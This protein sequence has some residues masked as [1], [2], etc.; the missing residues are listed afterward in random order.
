MM[1]PLITTPGHPKANS[2]IS[3]ESAND[4]MPLYDQKW[5]C[6]SDDEKVVLL[7]KS[8]MSLNA[9]PF[10]G[11]PMFRRQPLAFPR[12][13][14]ALVLSATS[15]GSVTHVTKTE[16]VPVK[17]IFNPD[18]SHLKN[19]DEEDVISWDVSE[20]T[21]FTSLQTGQTR[22]VHVFNH[23]NPDDPT[24]Q[25]CEYVAMVKDD[26]SCLWIGYYLIQPGGKKIKVKLPAESPTPHYDPLTGVFSIT[27]YR[28]PSLAPISATGGATIMPDTASVPDTGVDIIAES[29]E[30]RDYPEWSVGI[31]DGIIPDAAL[32]L[33]LD[34]EGVIY[35]GTAH[36]TDTGDNTM[37]LVMRV[38]SG[39]ELK[40]FDKCFLYYT[41]VID[42]EVTTVVPN[43]L[44]IA[45]LNFSDRTDF[46]P[47]FAV[48]G[49]VHVY[50]G[51]NRQY[52]N[53]IAH[54][55]STGI[56]TLDDDLPDWD[57]MQ[58]YYID[59]Y[60][61]DIV[62]AAQ[63]MLF[64]YAGVYPTDPYAG[65]GLSKITIGDTSR[66]YGSVQYGQ[67]SVK[68]IADRFGVT[69]KVISILGKYLVYGKME[70]AFQSRLEDAL[71]VELETANA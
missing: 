46:L 39:P 50:S 63:E 58:Y 23:I 35:R 28:D 36:I 31:E 64:K 22:E 45:D 33:D 67:M 24:T 13:Y 10:L 20:Y 34:K 61:A 2:Y 51:G 70:I 4:I 9:L 47:D 43:Q 57:G 62:K 19:T 49:G 8:A 42:E 26:G 3:L 14:D 5:D 48:G 60:P 17:H 53:V 18:V 12:I 7:R 32:V 29:V 38:Q 69:E 11:V 27:A 1:L 56:V 25:E 6:R 66:T 59:P 44:Q 30:K 21:G 65:L 55:V 52:Y 37:G 40:G 16:L 68:N 54:D 41:A 71:N 15:T